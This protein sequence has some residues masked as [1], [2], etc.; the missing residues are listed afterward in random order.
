MGGCLSLLFSGVLRR[1]LPSLWEELNNTLQEL[2]LPTLQY[3]HEL[4][5]AC[6]DRLTVTCELLLQSFVESNA[7]HCASQL[8][9]SQYEVFIEHYG[10]TSSSSGGSDKAGNA[11]HNLVNEGTLLTCKFLDLYA[12]L[13]C[14]VLNEAPP[15]LKSHGLDRDLMRRGGGAAAARASVVGGLG[16][17]NLQLDIERLFTQ[18]I[19]VFDRLPVSASLDLLVGAVIKVLIVVSLLV[20]LYF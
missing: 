19:K 20:A 12:L 1:L 3:R 4:R 17:H 11:A 18:R 16:H 9:R 14:V 8:T 15:P 6:L 7:L 2:D 13:C 5:S 10:P